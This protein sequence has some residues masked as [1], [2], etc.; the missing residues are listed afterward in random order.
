MTV[1]KVGI[2]KDI[3]VA[4]P[5]CKEL[6]YIHRLFYESQFNHLKLRCPFCHQEFA[7]ENAKTW[8]EK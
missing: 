1:E 5:T 8:G 3:W 7:K 2:P 6:F 4:C